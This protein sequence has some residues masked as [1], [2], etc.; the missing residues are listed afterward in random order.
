MVD[1]K[2]KRFMSLSPVK[3][4][5][6]FLDIGSATPQARQPNGLPKEHLDRPDA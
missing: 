6:K 2:N 1:A 5:Y 4:E 3:T